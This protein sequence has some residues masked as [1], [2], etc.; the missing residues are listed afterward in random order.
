MNDGTLLKNTQ[1][2]KQDRMYMSDL[3]IVI[4]MLDSLS[5]DQIVEEGEVFYFSFLC[6][7][8]SL[9]PLERTAL[10]NISRTGEE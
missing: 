8:L 9:S 6:H 10:V 7:V 1:C 4:L 5:A 2:K 3:L